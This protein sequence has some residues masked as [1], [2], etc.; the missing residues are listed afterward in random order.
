MTGVEVSVSERLGL[1]EIDKQ[2]RDLPL[3]EDSSERDDFTLIL[4]GTGLVV[5][6]STTSLAGGNTISVDGAGLDASS[7]SGRAEEDR[8]EESVG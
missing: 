1:I 5:N 7:T 2:I 3:D 4:N 6:G 8:E